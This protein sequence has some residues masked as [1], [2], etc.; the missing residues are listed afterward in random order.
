MS[1]YSVPSSWRNLLDSKFN[2][3]SRRK[4][5]KS[6]FGGTS[7]W[8]LV[9]RGLLSVLIGLGLRLRLGGM[10]GERGSRLNGGGFRVTSSYE[11]GSSQFDISS[12][13]SKLSSITPS[14]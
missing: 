13:F 10:G 4:S 6:G 11:G 7:D 1:V 5:G 8:L 2:S 3:A 12:S 14:V 9:D